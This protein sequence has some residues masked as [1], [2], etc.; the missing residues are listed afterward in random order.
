MLRIVIKYQYAFGILSYAGSKE[1]GVQDDNI[2][3]N[4]YCVSS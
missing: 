1:H 4:K 2:K 3:E